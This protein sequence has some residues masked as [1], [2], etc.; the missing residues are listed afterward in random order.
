M[1]VRVMTKCFVDNGLREV[2]AVF[3]Y[4]GPANGNLKPVNAEAEEDP[5]PDEFPP[6]EDPSPPPL[7]KKRIRNRKKKPVRPQP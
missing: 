2:G 4:N 5:R 1:L 7:K 6:D 3:E